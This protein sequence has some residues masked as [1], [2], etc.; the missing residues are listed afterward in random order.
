MANLCT[1]PMWNHD[2]SHSAC[3]QLNCDIEGGDVRNVP[4]TGEDCSRICRDDPNCN[5]FVHFNGV[6]YLKWQGVMYAEVR[7]RRK[8]KDGA[9]CGFLTPDFNYDSTNDV[10]WGRGCYFGYGGDRMSFAGDSSKCG[11]YCKYLRD[12]YNRCFQFQW[13]P[14]DGNCVV[15]PT[16][17]YSW[18]IVST[19]THMDTICG[20]I[21]H[22]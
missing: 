11:Q 5:N 4:S 1:Y 6:C 16:A 15:L 3:W 17:D 8:A 18:S 19:P 7:N 13:S 20:S 12:T 9:V 10:W 21:F 2:A 14:I 22:F